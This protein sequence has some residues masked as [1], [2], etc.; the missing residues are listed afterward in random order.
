MVA[1]LGALADRVVSLVVP[2]VA[3]GACNCNSCQVEVETI[4]CQTG[5]AVI[6]RDCKCEPWS[7]SCIDSCGCRGTC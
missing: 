7:R 5:C 2:N 6:C 1:A 4:Y 3:A